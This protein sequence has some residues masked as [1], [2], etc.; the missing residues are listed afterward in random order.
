MKKLSCVLLFG[1]YIHLPVLLS[2]R[3][4]RCAITSIRH[5]SVAPESIS[6]RKTIFLQL[7]DSVFYILLLACFSKCNF[8]C[9]CHCRSGSIAVNMTLIFVNSTVVPPAFIVMQQLGTALNGTTLNV[10]PGSVFAGKS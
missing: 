1:I 2:F 6:S 9:V 8:S 10:I 7:T 5:F 4:T 3:L